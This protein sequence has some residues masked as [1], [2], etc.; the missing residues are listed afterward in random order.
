MGI[1][2]GMNEL[3]ENQKTSRAPTRPLALL[4]ILIILI[5]TSIFLMTSLL[6]AR[7]S[8]ARIV[9]ENV[10]EEIKTGFKAICTIHNTTMRDELLKYIS[11]RVEKEIKR[12]NDG[13]EVKIK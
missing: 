1:V 8:M 7:V 9:I 12:T 10:P 4:K 13:L 3:H 2:E 11:S 5:I 6:K